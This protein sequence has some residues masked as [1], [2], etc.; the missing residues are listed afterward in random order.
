MNVDRF[1]NPYGILAQRD[2]GK[3]LKCNFHVHAERNGLAF[4]DILRCYKEAE[5]DIIMHS[6]QNSYYDTEAEG[7]EAGVKTFNGQEYVQYDGILLIGTKKFLSGTP[8]EVIDQCRSEGGFAVINHPNQ[9][10][11]DIKG[12]PP[13]LTK[14]MSRTLKNAV[15][16][17]IYNGCISRRN[18]F[19]FGL[20]FGLGT[21]FWDE[22]LSDAELLWGFGNDDF[23]EMFEMNVGWTEIYASSD[24]FGDVKAA[25]KRGSLYAS[26]GLYLHEY[27]FDGET[28][29]IVADFKYDRIERI[30]Y[31]F[32]GKNGE[33]LSE[34][35][36]AR[37]TYQIKGDE[38]YVRVEATAPDGSM[39]WAQPI[40]NKAF[41]EG[42]SGLIS[43][44]G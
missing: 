35:F 29:E 2:G 31:R 24:E 12:I 37:G 23:H 33:I 4:R 5:Y 18:F 30:R 9:K 27:R 40:L 34:D 7:D 20:G 14:E 43:E 11:A 6:A 8:Q 17:E 21:D 38:A 39:L 19:G 1:Y 26:N 13:V 41:F 15:G 32:I 3:W 22:R 28:I 25:V 16:L 44:E 42:A 36:G 10:P